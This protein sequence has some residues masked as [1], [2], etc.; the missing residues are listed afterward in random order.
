MQSAAPTA[1]CTLALGLLEPGGMPHLARA[2]LVAVSVSVC[3]SIAC[4]TTTYAPAGTA[5]AQSWLARNAGSEAGVL[6]A[7][8]GDAVRVVIEARSPTDIR[9]RPEGKGESAIADLRKVVIVRRPTGALEGA[10][11]GIAVGA[12]LGLLHGLTSDLSSYERSM[13]CTIVCS[14]ADAARWD[15]L[16]FSVP[17]LLLGAFTGA[18]IGHRDSLELR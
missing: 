7:A 9:F 5:N 8:G 4:S 13:D 3:C 14:K 17:G 6:P 18:L 12:S 11:I 15:A 16:F 10:L 1:V 2:A